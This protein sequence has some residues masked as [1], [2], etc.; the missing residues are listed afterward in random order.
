MM[1][2]TPPGGKDGLPRNRGLLGYGI[3]VVLAGLA[4]S[5]HQFLFGPTLD[6]VSLLVWASAFF[7][8]DAMWFR[9]PPD[10]GR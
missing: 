10:G 7:V 3:L 2:R 5:S 1:V 4:V 6:V 8:G 9:T